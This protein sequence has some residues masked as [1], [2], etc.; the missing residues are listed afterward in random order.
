MLATQLS[1]M[2]GGTATSAGG[3]STAN[4]RVI[5]DIGSAALNRMAS[6]TYSLLC[7][8]TLMSWHLLF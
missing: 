3:E 2:L 6:Y 4:M 1:G 7:R 8:F 5:V